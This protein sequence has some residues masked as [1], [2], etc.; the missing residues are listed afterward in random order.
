MDYRI[1]GSFEVRMEGRLV[2][3]G[4]E[5][6]RALLAILVLHRNEVV[7]A[8]RLIDDLWGESPPETA[9][10]TLRA[11]VS[12]L[13]K[14][15]GANGA[16]PDESDRASGADGGVLV[17]QGHGYV[18]RVAPGELDVERFGEM[19]DRGREALAARKPREAAAMLSEALAIWRGPPLADF[20]Y[21]PFAQ[22]SIAQL[23]EL[24]LAAIEDRVEADLALGRARNLVGELRDLV[25]RYPLRERLR[26]QLMLGLYRSG[27]QAEALEVFQEFRRTLSEELG[28]EPGPA[29]QQLELSILRRDP[30][31]DLA[32]SDAASEVGGELRTAGAPR[33]VVAIR[34]HR[35]TLA[36]GGAVML[37]LVLAA[38]VMA[39]RGGRASPRAG[40]PGDA[41]GAISPSGGAIRAVV[42]LGTAPSVLAA[43][44][45]AVW[46]ANG[47]AGTVSRIDPS[48]R[49][50][51][52]T[53]PVGSSPSGIAVAPGAVWVTDNYGNAVSRI[54]PAVDRVVQTI[55]VGNAPTG[56]AVADGSVWVVNSSDGTL[57]RIDATTGEVVKTI[58]LGAGASDVAVGAGAVWVSDAGG[59]RV[60][61]VDPRSDQVTALINVG[62]GPT[63]IAVGFGSVWVAN[64]LDGTVSRIDPQTDTVSATVAVG[65]GAGG[66]ALGAGG[67][68]V[69]DQ[70]AGTVALID[71]STNAVKRTIAVGSRPQ[72]PAL[73]GGLL[74]VDARPAATS[75]RGGTLVMLGTGNADTMDPV[76]TQNL[77][78]VLPLTYDGLTAYQRVGGSGSLE[79]VP[80]LAVS[81]PSPTESGTTYTFQLRRGIRYSNGQLVRPEDFRRALERDLILGGN[82]NYGGPFADVIGGAACAVGRSRCD[83]S[84]GVVTDDA[85]NTVTFHLVA[86]NPEFL[87]RLTLPDAYAVPAGTPNHDIGLQP[88]PATGPYQ[89]VDVSR[90]AVTLVR[91]P[92]FHEWSHAARPD[93]YPDRIVF[94]HVGSAE[95]G[96]T[97]VERGTADYFYDGVPQDRLGEVQ[98]RFASQLHITPTSGTLALILNTRKAPFTDRRVRQAIN[99]AID[100]AKIAQ[101]LGQGSQPACQILPAGLPGYRRYCPYTTDPN[102]AGAWHGPDLAKA[103][104]LIAASHTSGTRVTIWNLGAD[105]NGTLDTYLAS[106]LDRLGYP[107][108][109]KDFA[110]SD[111][112]APVRFADSRTTAQAALYWIP[113]G[114]LYPSASQILQANFACQSFVPGSPGN[115]NWSEFCDHRLDAQINTALAAES[116]NSPATA[117]L[118]AQADRTATDQAPAVPLTTTSDVHLVSERVGNYQYSFQQGVLLDQLW[119]R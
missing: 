51:V 94:R 55:P 40:I 85:A 5:K 119:V 62:N 100:R 17:T 63:A 73:A 87:E 14:A 8:D 48:T 39:A 37:T 84:R 108:Q 79:L 82:G 102:P 64:S 18:L 91:N 41:V 60:F 28:L 109:V 1:L 68:W 96:L 11:Y 30:A 111:P 95:A 12:R 27:R 86:P 22:S 29:I 20:A 76:L 98:T 38:V 106:L 42:S 116:N 97:A 89:W 24:R 32:A 93:G 69:A 59:A 7:S 105:S 43:G 33:R 44:D 113:I 71:P 58:A 34:R 104:R 81:L 74:W 118:W 112:T 49:A 36:V 72:G 16:S 3:L 9:L 2:G 88:L 6:P 25:A 99:Y 114:A 50:V 10:R 35:L 90:D 4:G 110:S 47:N 13:R 92:Y 21:E 83:L 61:R 78:G 75:H 117:S 53:I 54:D 80:D 23:E 31:L 101:L 65:D 107:T 45:G 56:V 70:Y 67:V 19:A 66:I 46:V 57:T 15:L 26:G 103:E 52:E 77:G 115:S